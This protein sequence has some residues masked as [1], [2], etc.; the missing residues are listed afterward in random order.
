MSVFDN[1][2][3]TGGSSGLPA[4]WQARD[5]GST[6]V[7][8]SASA[9]AGTF[10]VKGAGADIW[11][12]ADAFHI[13]Y[14]TMTGN[15]TV[16]A[17]VASMVGTEAWTKVGV[18]IRAGSSA[19]AAHAS[20]LVSKS[21]GLAFQR[22]VT[23]GGLSTSTSGGTGTAP[24]WVRLARAGN[25][26]TASVSSNGTSWTVVGSETIAMPASVLV[27]LVVSSHDPTQVATATFDNVA[28]TQ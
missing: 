9:S 17:R 26:I 27:G 12:S 6:G 7:A 23:T 20:M 4:D 13:A 24:R 22:R 25:V 8:G 15:A 11:A 10:T 5:I 1:V 2:T 21:K 28:V 14:R 3:V 18:M 16:T 19:G